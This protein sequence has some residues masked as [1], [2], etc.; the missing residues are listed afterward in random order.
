MEKPSLDRD[1]LIF[2]RAC[3]LEKG[4]QFLA[5]FQ[6]D[7]VSNPDERLRDYAVTLTIDP[8]SQRPRNDGI[9]ELTEGRYYSSRKDRLRILE[10]QLNS[11]FIK[12]RAWE[13]LS[14][15]D[16]DPNYAV[17]GSGKVVNPPPLVTRRI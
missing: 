15:R 2:S 11:E 5:E 16:P 3:R 1:S 8:T 13:I 14:K 4:I 6:A 17:D 7:K 10:R 12:T 9:W